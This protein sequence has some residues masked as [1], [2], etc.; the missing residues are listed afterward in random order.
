MTGARADGSDRFV[1]GL[2][3]ARTYTVRSHEDPW[4]LV[5]EFERVLD[6]AASNPS[7]G[8]SAI[9]TRLDLPRSRIREWLRDDEPARPDCVRGIDAAES[10]GWV[11]VDPR[12]R[13]FYGLNILVAWIFSG[14]SI[15]ERHHVPTFVLGGWNAEERLEDAFEKVGVGFQIIREDTQRQ[16]TEGRPTEHSAVLGRVLTTL[17]APIG[18]KKD[19]RGLTLPAY[20]SQVSTDLRFDF[21]RTY[22]ANRGYFHEDKGTISFAEERSDRYLQELAGF[23]SDVSGAPVTTSEFN[24]FVSADAARAL[25]LR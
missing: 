2:E 16:A 17:G 24:V 3:L 25:N 12:D 22:V 23:L 20:L 1:T 8:D 6:Y 4:D 19:V 10:R 14:G 5:L 13:T 11:N 18:P 9:S 7:L 15:N 21:A